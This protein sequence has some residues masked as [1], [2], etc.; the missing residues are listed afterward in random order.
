MCKPNMCFI[1]VEKNIFLKFLF[2]FFIVFTIAIRPVLPM[3]N[4]MI[5]YE[6]IVKN[7]CENRKLKDFDCKGKCYIS[8]EIEKS[9]KQSGNSQKIHISSVDVFVPHDI[10]SVEKLRHCIL[11]Q[12]LSLNLTEFHTS[13]YFS[14]IFRPPLP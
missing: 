11:V 14:K 1:F 9:E 2:S 6:Y 5:N 12:D 13:E 4:Y 7:L 8:K 10:F 3:L